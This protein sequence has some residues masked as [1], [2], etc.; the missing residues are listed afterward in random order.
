MTKVILIGMVALVAGGFLGSRFADNMEKK[1]FLEE[2]SNGK[3]QNG[4]WKYTVS[5]QPEYKNFLLASRG[6]LGGT[7]EQSLMFMTNVSSDGKILKTGAKYRITGNSIP[8]SNWSLTAYHSDYLIPGEMQ[9]YCVTNTSVK[10]NENGTWEAF[11]TPDAMD[12]ENWIYS[13]K[14]GDDLVLVLRVYNPTPDV[15]EN[16][17]ELNL[18]EIEKL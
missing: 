18:P 1:K 11:L 14:E 3:R 5:Q 6:V 17:D 9:K 13:G 16:M 8:S 10:T 15:I 2:V 12:T 7:N 4:I